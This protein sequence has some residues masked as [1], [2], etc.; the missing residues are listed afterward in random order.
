MKKRFSNI[1]ETLLKQG[2]RVLLVAMA[3]PALSQCTDLDETP[4]TSISPGNFYKSARDIEIAL[5]GVY[6]RIGDMVSSG[7]YNMRLEVMTEFN[8]P[9]YAKDDVEKWNAWLNVNNADMAM[10]VWSTG[11]EIINRANIVLGYSPNIEMDEAVRKQYMGEAYFL[12]AMANFHLM[13]LYGRLPIPESY[14]SGD[15]ELAIPRKSLEETYAHIIECLELAESYLPAKNEYSKD[16]DIWRASKGAAQGLL[17]KVYLYRASMQGNSS[18]YT[19]VKEYCTKLMSSGIYGLEPNFKDL[20]F[21]YNTENKFGIESVFEYSFGQVS[22]CYNNLHVMLG[23]NVTD[24]ELGCYMYRRMGPSIP[25]YLSYATNDTRKAT[26]LD[27]YID[28]NGNRCWFD[29]EDKGYYPNPRPSEQL[30]NW[31]TASPGNIKYYDKTPASA[32]LQLPAANIYGIRYADVLLMFAEAENQLN[33]PTAEALKAFND[34]RTRAGLD[35]LT[36][37]DKQEFDDWIYRE[38]GWEFVGEAQLYFDGLRTGRLA[39]NVKAHL[40]D[41]KQQG[42]YM[43]DYDPGFLPTK[44]FLWKIPQGD[45]DSN[46]ALEQNPDN[47]SAS[48]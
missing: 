14:T 1:K 42:I 27:E 32:N 17:A 35:A 43:Y 12:K 25:H 19:K 45:L 40:I 21:W 39:A 4:Y 30:N 3:I 33:G 34:V 38:R 36:T 28:K 10:T 11:F 23:I 29:P 48:L 31:T 26:F 46:S 2:A 8:S 7:N 24:P 16:T 37:G 41:G 9:A 6:S 15:S 18:D 22:G 13:R 5:N 47:V 20:W 44:D